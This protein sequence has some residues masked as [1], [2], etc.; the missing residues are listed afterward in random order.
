MKWLSWEILT[1]YSFLVQDE[2]QGYHWKETE[3]SL[4]PVV[5]YICSSDNLVESS[6]CILS[7]DLNHDVAF[8]YKVVKETVDFI[9]KELN[10]SVKTIHDFS[11]GCAAQYK[12]CKHFVNLCHH[13]TD[14]SIDCMW[15]FLTSHG[16]SPCDVIGGTMKRLTARAS[17]QCPI[18]SQILSGKTMFE[19][20]QGSIHQINFIYTSSD[21]IDVIWSKLTSL[22]SLARKIPGT[23]SY[24]QFVPT[25]TFS[26]K[27]K[28][29]RR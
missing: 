17:L 21:E 22:F 9:K 16:K 3:C 4:H 27:M 19:F 24:H 1:N 18:S 10:P 11:D 2:I 6:L 5:V 8:V 28:S 7:E 29:I 20:C 25:S 23:W 26:I 13:L 14:F 15:N 12:N